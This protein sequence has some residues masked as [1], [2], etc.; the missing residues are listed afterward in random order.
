[1]ILNRCPKMM[2]KKI[3]HCKIRSC[4]SEPFPFPVVA[5][6]QQYWMMFW[7]IIKRLLSLFS[8]SVVIVGYILYLRPEYMH[9]CFGD[10]INDILQEYRLRPGQKLAKYRKPHMPIIMIPGMMSTGLELWQGMEC[11]KSRFR[12][13]FWTSSQMI[14]NVGTDSQC[15]FKHLS[16]NLSTWYFLRAW[17]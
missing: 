15:W 3:N 2:E 5:K 11:A 13:R 7:G 6:N 17:M 10:K 16:L 12:H 8:V 4:D 1:M 9:I 14:H